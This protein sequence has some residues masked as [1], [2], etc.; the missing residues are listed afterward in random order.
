M[1]RAPANALSAPLPAPFPGAWAL[2]ILFVPDRCPR[3]HPAPDIEQRLLNAG[4][5]F[6]AVNKQAFLP[7]FRAR[8]GSLLGGFRDRAAAVKQRHSCDGIDRPRP[9]PAAAPWNGG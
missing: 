7:L 9:P 3:S 8:D 5:P 1:S 2:Q 4:R 6:N